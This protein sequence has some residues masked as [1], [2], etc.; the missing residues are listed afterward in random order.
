MVLIDLADALHATLI[1]GLQHLV[2][3]ILILE[4]MG[5]G[6]VHQL[7]AK[8]GRLVLIAISYLTPYLAEQLL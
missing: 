5:N 1:K 4:I 2:K 6:L 3:R 7:V 8:N